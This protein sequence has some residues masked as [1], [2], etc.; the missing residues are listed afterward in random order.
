MI[1]GS[2]PS[3]DVGGERTG[4]ALSDVRARRGS[5][6]LR[7]RDDGDGDAH[8]DLLQQPDGGNTSGPDADLRSLGDQ[9]GDG[10][11]HE[12]PVAGAVA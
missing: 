9:P 1:Y 5:L 12:D 2:S 4:R 11:R 3:D 10:Y 7:R 6:G 8:F